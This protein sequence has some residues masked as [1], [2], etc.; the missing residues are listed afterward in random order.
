MRHR[1]RLAS[2]LFLAVAAM[3]AEAVGCVY[4]YDPAEGCEGPAC[5]AGGAAGGPSDPTKNCDLT[6]KSL[7]PDG[8]CGVFVRSSAG[9]GGDGSKERPFQSF[10]EA[11]ATSP[12]RV[13]ACGEA[14]EKYPEDTGVI[15]TDGV[16]IYGGFTACDGAWTWSSEA[17]A[18]LQGPAD[19][20]ALTLNGGNNR[21]ENVDIAAADASAADADSP[22]RSSIALLANG[23]AV[24]VVN[25][26]L[27]AGD[28]TSGAPA[29]TIAEDPMLD[30][31]DGEAGLAACTPGAAHEGPAGP[32]TR[33][34]DGQSEGGKGGDGGAVTGTVASPMRSDAGG[35]TS[36]QPAASQPTQGAGGTGETAGQL[37]TEGKNGAP[38]DPGE[39]AR[40]S[41]GLG[42]IDASGYTGAPAERGGTG[43]PGQGGGGG[44]GARGGVAM[45]GGTTRLLLPGAS[46]G[47][48]GSGGC[49]GHGG[50][51]GHPGGSSFALVVINATISLDGVSLVAGDG[52]DGGPG[53]E[54]QFGGIGGSGGE[55]GD[56]AGDAEASCLGGRGGRGG[57]GGPGG[58]GHGGHS[59]GVA[60]HGG[61]LLTS[62]VSFEAGAEGTGGP[63]AG[64]G[65]NNGAS[66]A[67]GLAAECWN[68]AENTP[69][70]VI[71][72]K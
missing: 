64:T 65:P 48:G 45:C 32:V 57:K 5:T 16:K 46:G 11:A 30:G 14:G 69:C 23:G 9:A 26:K 39:P 52:G 63:G 20:I 59:L 10:A 53:G 19:A 17:R 66:G 3:G 8:S 51:G 34:A 44:G 67:N 31:I 36:G 55:P 13:Y 42:T 25:G 15:F 60:F 27:E 70:S 12:K 35:G 61:E 38:G 28:A 54:G 58:G 68:F 6:D 1:A 50:H 47:A 40:P 24:T 37:C 4:R 7:P 33:C 18:T 49:G 71:S 62:D 29:R 56:P 2:V 41:E 21:L 43:K 72:Q 22:G